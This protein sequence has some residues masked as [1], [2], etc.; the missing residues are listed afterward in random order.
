M[1]DAG[2]PR[3][4]IGRT[5]RARVVA[6]TGEAPGFPA[7]WR[8]TVF[9]VPQ[10]PSAWPDT[11]AIVT[12]HNPGG[13]PASPRA[14]AKGE[15]ALAAR[16]AAL[17]L[18]SFVVIG[19]SPDFTHRE[20]GRGF[21]TRDIPATAALARGFGQLGFFW[22]E[23]GTVLVCTDDSGRGWPVGLWQDR[24]RSADR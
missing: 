21:A 2:L 20:P 16:L 14:N 10:P 11:F 6:P 23:C 12:A 4:A 18:D 1:T 13:R 5:P 8:E 22:V 7:S 15:A 19:S 17:G 3:P 9:V 24:L